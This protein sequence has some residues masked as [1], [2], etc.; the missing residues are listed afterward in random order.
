MVG[1]ATVY[2]TLMALAGQPRGGIAIPH[3]DAARPAT[4]L[5]LLR[6]RPI[7]RGQRIA[8]TDDPTI[9]WSLQSMIEKSAFGMIVTPKERTLESTW[10]AGTAMKF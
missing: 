10:L 2:V 7:E 4:G 1:G 6:N 9:R 8:I 3:L 5:S